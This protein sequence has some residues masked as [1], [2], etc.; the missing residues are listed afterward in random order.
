V[1]VVVV[2]VLGDTTDAAVVVRLPI[3][4]LSSCC[5]PLMY[6]YT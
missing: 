1:A 6:D 5:P 2:V 3:T 4:R